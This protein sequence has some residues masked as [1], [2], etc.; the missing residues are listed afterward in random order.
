MSINVSLNFMPAFYTKHTGT[1]YGEAF[2]FDIAHREKVERTESEFL[3]D[4]FGAHGVGAVHSKPSANIF[5]QPVDLIMRTQ[6]AEWIFPED[7]TVESLGAPW[8]GKSIEEIARIDAKAAASHPV[9]DTVLEQYEAM[10]MRYGNADIFGVKSG[11]MTIHTPYTTAQRLT[12]DDI[13]VHIATD[14]PGTRIVLDKVWEIYQAIYGRI[15]DVLS[16]KLTRVNMGDCAASMLSAEHYRASVLPVNSMIASSFD[17]AT[18]HSC[19]ASTHLINAFAALPH[20]NAIQ[21]GPG[22][23]IAAAVHAM[24]KI[25]MQ[26]LI[27]PL[28]MLNRTPDAVH[29]AIEQIINDSAKAPEITLCAWS[30]DRDTPFDAVN[31]LYDAVEDLKK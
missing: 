19:G 11:V 26:P 16:V 30:F 29:T 28:L 5:I 4:T 13:F 31:A 9:I 7:G 10:R 21:L 14:P 25:H 22:T 15:A 23:D 24:P 2:Y 18:Y 6:G 17:S 20:V 12:S 3:H 1:T 8:R 27:D